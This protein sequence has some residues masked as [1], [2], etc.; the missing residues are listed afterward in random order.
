MPSTESLNPRFA[1]IDR[2]PT[3]EAVEAMLEGQMSAIASIKS[4]TQLRGCRGVA[5]SSMS[6]RE[7]R[8]GLPFRTAS[9]WG[10]PLD[11]R[12]SACYI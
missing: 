6:A 1:D 12:L 8:D 3:A 10:R 7:L 5:G 4:Q 9:N 2:W 11:G